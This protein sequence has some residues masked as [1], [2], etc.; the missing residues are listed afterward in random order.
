MAEVVT[1]NKLKP[2]VDRVLRLTEERN[3]TNEMIKEVYAEAKNEGFDVKAMKKAIAD[4]Q[5]DA[6]DVSDF[7]ETVQLYRDAMS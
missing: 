7:E 1:I 3:A 5:K 4:I 2:L 6:Q